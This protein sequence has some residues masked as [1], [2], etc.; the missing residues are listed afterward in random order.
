MVR[1][2]SLYVFTLLTGISFASHGSVLLRAAEWPPVEFNLANSQIEKA[3]GEPT[4]LEFIET[5]LQDV[6][7]FL[8]DLHGIEIQIDA[9]ALEDIG[10]GSD[11]PIT[12]NL[13][14]I[15]LRSALKLML[16]ETKLQAVV[17]DE[18]LLVT[19][20]DALEKDGAAFFQVYDVE[21]LLGEDAGIEDLVAVITGAVDDKPVMTTSTFRGLLVV[22]GTYHQHTQLRQLLGVMAQALKVALP[23]PPKRVAERERP[24]PREARP[25]PRAA[26]RPM[27]PLDPTRVA[28]PFGGADDPFGAPAGGF[29]DGADPFRN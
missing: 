5:P 15:T 9:R 10:I 23:E 26:A 25:A 24:V 13:K 11:R 27:P 8:K 19:T 20:Q 1:F 7:D 14:G 2:R 28:D 21:P 6:V 18:V 17:R 16:D 29:D 4:T 22:R 12:C 3:L